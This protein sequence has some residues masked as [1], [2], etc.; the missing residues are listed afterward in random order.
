MMTKNLPAVLILAA[1]LMLPAGAWG[2][3]SGDSTEFQK[4]SAMYAVSRVSGDTAVLRWSKRNFADGY[5]VSWGTSGDPAAGRIIRI[6]GKELGSIRIRRLKNAD[7]IRF[8]IRCYKITG[9]EKLVSPWTEAGKQT[10]LAGFRNV[11]QTGIRVKRSSVVLSWKEQREKDGGSGSYV[12]YRREKGESVWHAVGAVTDRGG[13]G[14]TRFTDTHPMENKTAEY[15]VRRRSIFVTAR[16]DRVDTGLQPAENAPSNQILFRKDI[17]SDAAEKTAS[18]ETDSGKRGGAPADRQ[19]EWEP[20]QRVTYLKKNGR[21]LNVRELAER[22]LWGYYT[23]QGACSDGNYVYMAFV[24]RRD[25]YRYAKIM[26][27]RLRDLTCDR[28]SGRL[29]IGHANDMTYDPERR[30]LITTACNKGT[31]SKLY[32]DRISASN[33]KHL[34]RRKIRIPASVRGAGGARLRSVRGFSAVQY[35]GQSRQFYLKI[36]GQRAFFVLDRD[37]RI[38]SYFIA[39]GVRQDVTAQGISVH[40]GRFLRAYSKAQSSDRNLV[41]SSEGTGGKPK[42]TRLEVTGELES[43]FSVGEDLYGTIHRRYRDRGGRDRVF[44]YIIRIEAKK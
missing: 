16:P 9:G 22:K 1:G 31:G 44:S 37:F 5:E 28:V 35:D 25:N 6:R 40:K 18:G 10:R 7:R 20:G 26:K 12:V 19:T 23:T 32:V 21:A 30:E 11:R 14:Q 29:A 15:T 24:L 39:P 38:K 4:D 41:I 8:R 42:T 43:L 13:S 2:E 3:T 17:Q 36:W 27:I 33:L 34:E